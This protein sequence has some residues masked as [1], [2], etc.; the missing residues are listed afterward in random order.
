MIFH[1]YGN[2]ENKAVVLIHGML[3]PWQIWNYAIE[4]FSKDYYV[5]VPELDGHTE[6]EPSR[7]Y[8]I[9]TEADVIGKYIEK[10]LNNEVYLLAGI[11]MGGAIASTI[12]LYFPQ[13]L[14]EHLVLDGAPLR[15][16]NGILQFIMIQ[17]YRNLIKR[18]RKRD[19]KLIERSKKEFLPEEYT[20]YYLKIADN[21]DIYDIRWMISTV[22]INRINRS[23]PN[24]IKI[25]FMHGTKGNESV[26]AKSA[27]TVKEFNPQTEIRVFD[28]LGHAELACFK[29]EQWYEEVRSFICA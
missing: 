13:M 10:E 26:A 14:I 12:A 8:S 9:G 17:N 2:K 19:S 22:F 1:T 7:F 6:D 5:V 15:K 28:G 11:S 27:L 3:T 29:P 18:S 24:D 4:K 23:Y 16:V 21:M 20:E 25:L